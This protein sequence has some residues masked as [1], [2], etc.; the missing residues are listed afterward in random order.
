MDEQ[1]LD[2][3][4]DLPGRIND[5]VRRWSE[6][7]PNQVA[8]VDPDGAW[9]YRELDAA[10]GRTA[11]YLVSS[12]VR[13]GDRVMI[14]SENC[15][16]F[17]AILFALTQID[18]V[19]VPINARLSAR[20]LNS[21]RHHCNPR[22]LVYTAGVSPDALEHAKRDRAV[23]EE[24][25]T[26]GSIALGPLE[27]VEPDFVD[28]DR[29]KA[30]AAIL[31]TSGTTGDP[32]GV[33]LTHRNLLF[34]AT[35]S[36]KIR[37]LTPEDQLLGALPTSHAAGLQ[38][39]LLGTLLSGA[40]VYLLPRFDLLKVNALLQKDLLTILY[41]VPLMF[42]QFV[43]YAKVRGLKS[44][45]SSRLRIISS[46]G[47]PL[48]PVMKSAVEQLFGLVLNNGYGV[49]ECS[50]GIATTRIGSPRSDTSVGQ[51]YPGI[52][53]KLLGTDQEKVG[54]GEVGELW[55]RGPNIM[56]GYYRAPE[57][58]AKAINSEGW[59]NTQDLVRIEDGNLF[60]VGR[61]KELII[62]FGFNVYPAEIEAVF[63][64]H[65]E[66]IRSAVVGR[67][68]EETGEQEIIAYI[69]L[70]P[71]SR[72]TTS[73]LN[74]FAAQHLA[75]YKHPTQIHLVSGMPLTLSEKVV[76]D[77]LSSAFAKELTVPNGQG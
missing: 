39:H 53:V 66:V 67:S 47:S 34:A 33:M 46:C 31:Y 77:R 6:H 20:E 30:V 18:A 43:E 72:A 29:A 36:A 28:P 41:G 9:T 2:I 4:A 17:V 26:L 1:P 69:Q 61:R 68:L 65:P 35:A 24:S 74:R 75:S 58:T 27:E 5:A 70:V 71:E 8:L 14:V 73:E 32:K 48:Q 50:A 55:V 57:E 45:R 3:V 49:T 11:A 40:T 21:I 13:P 54:D 15:R 12:G 23:I 16:A 10:I 76:K 38:M 63:N 59:F 19:P 42:A 52:E 64:M 25:V 56:K 7:L 51:I 44:L 60:V 62:R 37:S 22:R